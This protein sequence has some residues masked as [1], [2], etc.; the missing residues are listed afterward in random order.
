MRKD[1]NL[2]TTGQSE[3]YGGRGFSG[4]DNNNVPDGRRLKGRGGM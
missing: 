2:D 4:R 1:P 3:I